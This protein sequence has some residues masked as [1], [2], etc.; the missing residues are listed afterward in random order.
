LVG[1]GRPALSSARLSPLRTLVL[2]LAAAPAFAQTPDPPASRP[3][4]PVVEIIADLDADDFDRRE[5]ATE[6]LVRLG[7]DARAALEAARTEGSLERR[8]RIDALLARLGSSSG[9][10]S[11]RSARITLDLKSRPLREACEALAAASGYAVRSATPADGER[12]VDVQ[13][14]DAPFFAA[15]DALAAAAGAQ[16]FRD[17]RDGV[18][19]LRVSAEK[20]GP[21]TYVD[22]LRV[23]LSSISVTR[24]TRFGSAASSS[25]FIQ[26]QVDA[27]P[28]AGILGLL[29]PITVAEATD[30]QGRSLLPK[31]KQQVNYVQRF[32]PAGRVPAAAMLSP[33]ESDAKT[34]KKLRFDLKVVV[35]E[36]TAEVEIASPRADPENPRGDGAL[37]VT[38]E[39]WREGDDGIAVRLTIERPVAE[40]AGPPNSNISDDQVT[41][42]DAEGGRVQP[43]T[44]GAKNLGARADYHAELPKGS[45]ASLRVSSLV[46][47]AVRGVSATFEEIA[48]P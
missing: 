21:A 45:Y 20:G 6:E 17:P 3:A 5:R 46:K 40:G 42:V 15:L 2:F 27:E 8:L 43:K 28:G 36:Q 41:F 37:R 1:R 31:E 33:P 47:F 11:R 30:E 23:A 29:A 13:C 48:L 14:E 26:L 35:P 4:R 24:M 38:I 22:G 7:A 34:L 12:L 10:A 44:S 9:A 32:D 39:E 16:Q 18:Y 19:V 25:A